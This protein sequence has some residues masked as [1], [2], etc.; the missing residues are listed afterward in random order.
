MRRR[1]AVVGLWPTPDQ[2]TGAE[3]GPDA[4]VGRLELRKGYSP[5]ELSETATGLCLCDGPGTMADLPH[6]YPVHRRVASDCRVKQVGEGLPWL[7]QSLG[8]A[9]WPQGNSARAS[10]RIRQS[11]ESNPQVTQNPA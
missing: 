9:F 4:E 11:V 7:R 8:T 3:V 10:H 1:T 2:A 5:G 6:Q